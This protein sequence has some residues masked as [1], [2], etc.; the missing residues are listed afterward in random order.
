MRVAE[1]VPF[2]GKISLKHTASQ[3]LA[4]DAR[5]VVL[6]VNAFLIE[7]PAGLFL[8]DTG[9]CRDVS[10]RGEYDAA[11]VER[12]LPKHLAQLYRPWLPEGMA[13]HEQL[14]ARGIQPSDLDAV[15]L[16]HLDPDHVAGLKHVSGAKRILLAED[17]YFW[18]CRTIYRA[19]QPQSLYQ[20]IEMEH[21]WYRGTSDG[22]NRW[23][24][25][26]LG[27]GTILLV[28]V[29]GHTDGQCAVLITNGELLE[30]KQ[31][32]VL[33]TAD[34]AFAPRNWEQ[35]I[36]PGLGFDVTHQRRALEWIAAKAKHPGCRAV[37]TSHDPASEPQTV[38]V[39]F[40]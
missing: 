17:E 35:M 13:I 40:L 9:W 21:F 31:Q 39:D 20:G 3:L 32:L 34:A 15:I 16:T 11:A 12:V 38:C 26:L 6:P 2:G 36:T 28:N 29:P 30:H 18:T 19:R 4:P 25:D 14:A 23:A 10:P 37:F 5:R 24:F 22:P 7:H 27:D 33:L 1:S 8:V